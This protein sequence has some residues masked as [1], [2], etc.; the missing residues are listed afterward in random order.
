MS[1][2]DQRLGCALFL[3]LAAHTSACLRGHRPSMYATATV[4]TMLAAV[5]ISRVTVGRRRS[6]N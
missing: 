4:T 6:K 1:K 3:S 5:A 2:E